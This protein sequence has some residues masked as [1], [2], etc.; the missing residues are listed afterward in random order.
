MNPLGAL[1]K[2]AREYCHRFSDHAFPDPDGKCW[3][4]PS[5][6][7]RTIFA[8]QGNA[9]CIKRGTVSDYGNASEVGKWVSPVVGL[10]KWVSP[11]KDVGHWIGSA[12]KTGAWVAK[13]TEHGKMAAP[14]II[15]GKASD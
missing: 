2:N 6:W 5:G 9:A 14:A 8:V 10:G 15:Y 1:S 7:N 13:A 4:C 3:T 12:A 11:V